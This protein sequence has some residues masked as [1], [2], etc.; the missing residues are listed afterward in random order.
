MSNYC[1]LLV[2]QMLG[3][4]LPLAGYTY[5][6]WDEPN[7]FV[8]QRLLDA[9]SAIALRSGIALSTSNT[10][11]SQGYSRQDT[12]KGAK[13]NDSLPTLEELE[14]MAASARLQ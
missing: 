6:Y 9:Q 14:E 1:L 13:S 5:W 2:P 10:M 3:L 12:S 4:V 11:V 7:L 8:D